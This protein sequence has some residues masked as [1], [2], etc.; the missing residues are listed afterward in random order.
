MW[1]HYASSHKGFCVGLDENQLAALP[2]VQGHGPV[3]Y[4]HEAPAFRFFHDDQTE[5]FRK[6]FT[7][8]SKAWAYEQEYRILFERSGLVAIPHSAIREVILG[9]RA[10]PELREFARKRCASAGNFWMQI[11]EDFSAYR[12]SKRAIEKDVFVMSSFF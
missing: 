4:Q 2:E 3:D 1:S 10:F 11:C 9:C 5:F 7:Y 6:A 8:K 12:L